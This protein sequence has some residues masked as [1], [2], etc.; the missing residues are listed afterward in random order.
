MHTDGRAPFDV[1]QSRPRPPFPAPSSQGNELVMRTPLPVPMNSSRHRRVRFTTR[2][3]GLLV[4]ASFVAAACGG[5]DD[6]TDATDATDA[7]TATSAAADTTT[8]GDT[9]ETSTGDASGGE[10][11]PRDGDFSDWKVVMIL[12]GSSEDGGWNTAHAAGGA[13]DRG[14]RS[15]A[16]RSTTSRRSPPARP[17]PT[18]SRTRSP[19]APT[20]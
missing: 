5:D 2:L 19:P 20:W 13:D 1:S 17:R 3:A 4:A 14:Q 6:S 9:T 15:P 11:T 7:P 12:D 10:V 8:G 18:R 16:S